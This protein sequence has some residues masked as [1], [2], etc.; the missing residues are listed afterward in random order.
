[1]RKWMVLV[2]AAVLA[3]GVCS[4]AWAVSVT[5]ALGITG[6]G[7]S[8]VRGDLSA[9]TATDL[10]VVTN[11]G[12]GKLLLRIPRA[13]GAG[14]T[15]ETADS[16]SDLV[17]ADDLLYFL[18]VQGGTATLMRRNTDST[19][20]E[21]Y[22]FPAG[23]AVSA[24]SYCQGNLY[25][26]I[27]NQLHMIYPSTGQC[28]MLSGEKMLD[29][30]I[31]GD[32]L[33][34]VSESDRMTYSAASLLADGE[35]LS[36]EAGC[37]YRMDLT[38]S[39]GSLVIKTGVEDLRYYDGAL[40]FHNL[41]DNY[42]MGDDTREWLE[43]KLY[44]YDLE[45]EQLTRLVNGYDWGFFPMDGGVAVYTSGD[46]SFYNNLGGLEG[47]MCSPDAYAVLSGGGDA[48]VVY[49]PTD[50]TVLYAYPNGSTVSAYEGES[51]YVE[52]TQPDVFAE[53]GENGEDGTQ[54]G[55]TSKGGDTNKSGGQTQTGGRDPEW[56]E[57]NDPSSGGSGST[58]SSGSVPDFGGSYTEKDS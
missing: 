18:R 47:S 13:G 40:F 32:A 23:S 19:R 26:L 48:V 15:V 31:V 25:A 24:L 9:R 17:A 36:A 56:F 8:S 41:S 27:N 16:I 39:E 45:H 28:V 53:G 49:S 2:L 57:S 34:Y 44:R 42:V 33:Y 21:I 5:D 12:A 46:L 10:Y 20:S 6:G 29:Y 52:P 30:A 50:N 37:L 55:D 4:P 38:G 11:D 51:D 7:E 3:L 54:S 58:S 14:V 35:T 1:M 43:G 22:T